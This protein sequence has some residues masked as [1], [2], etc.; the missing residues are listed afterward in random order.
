MIRLLNI[1][2]FKPS[3]FLLIVLFSVTISSVKAG[4]EPNRVLISG[5]V[6]HVLY[7]GPIANHSVFVISI[8][9]GTT[10]NYYKELI[11]NNEGY[12]FDTIFT[13]KNS[14]SYVISTMDKNNK[15]YENTLHFRF[16]DNIFSNI[17]LSNFYIDA[18]YQTKPLQSRFK[19]VKKAQG[20][21]FRYWFFDQTTNPNVVAWH[22]D[23]GDGTTS[24]LQ[25]PEHIYT[26]G[27]LFKVR[28][29]VT[30]RIFSH[31]FT[32]SITQL[33]Y[34]SELEYFHLGGHV[35]AQHMPI[36]LGLAF[37]YTVDSSNLFFPVDTACIDT[38]GYYYFY[39]VPLGDY[40]VKS[41][42]NRNSTSYGAYLPTYFG[43]SLYW[44]Q[45]R[46]IHLDHTSWEYDINLRQMDNYSPG[47][48]TIEGTIEYNNQPN[49][50]TFSTPAIGANVYLM[51][52]DDRMLM[53][54][55][56]NEMGLFEFENMET[57]T[58]WVYPEIA[59]ITADKIRVDLSS[60]QPNQNGI[61]ITVFE[62]MAIGINDQH[63]SSVSSI[64]IYPNPVS[65]VLTLEFFDFKDSDVDVQ[66]YDVNG[67]FVQA[68]TFRSVFNTSVNLDISLVHPGLY[69]LKIA[70]GQ[71][72]TNRF[73]VVSR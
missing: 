36:D 15:P 62:Q 1:P 37:L 47:P 52:E 24:N 35:F 64:N 4:C 41:E 11:T 31:T 3:F 25:N 26:S 60:E 59:G 7:G 56:A 72:I 12:F 23:F 9:D 19:Y 68:Q 17:L 22:W 5:Q 73:I 57:K 18:L 40:V 33:I 32:N 16:G 51:D 69:L 6:L 39:Q 20:D 48:G 10:R 58:Y 29:T 34:I 49:G 54:S 45:A 2:V 66:L 13:T 27:N 44:Q 30:A 50:I 55:K 38:L 61:H 70:R 14:G 42:L 28:L 46:P 71:A 65:S 8:G 43:D 67:R 21:R 63:E 53:Y